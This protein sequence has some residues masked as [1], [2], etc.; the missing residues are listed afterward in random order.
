VFYV[1]L[2]GEGDGCDYGLGADLTIG[3]NLNW[4]KLK[5]EN[6]S[7]ARKEVGK[8]VKEYKHIGIEK[9]I[10]LEVSTSEVFDVQ[11]FNRACEDLKV[12]QR[13]AKDKADRK[14]QYEKLKA[15]FETLYPDIPKILPA[16]II[17]GKRDGSGRPGRTAS[18]KL[19]LPPVGGDR[20]Q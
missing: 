8:I 7:D 5:A 10:V 6:W 16:T 15:E 4:K 19:K 13:I 3:C 1:L 12:A 11:A 2:R 20:F 9:A 14:S 17:R 18:S